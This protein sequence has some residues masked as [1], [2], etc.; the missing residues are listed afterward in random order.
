M[1]V[2]VDEFG[3]AGFF[4][5]RDFVV[6]EFELGGGQVVFELVCLAGADDGGGHTGAVRDPGQGHLGRGYAV[7]VADFHQRFDD[8]EQAF[9]IRNGRFFPAFGKAGAFGFVLVAAVFA[10][11]QAA[12]QRRPYP[13]TVYLIALRSSAN[14][15]WLGRGCATVRWCSA[16][17][18]AFN[19]TGL[20]K[21]TVTRYIAQARSESEG[22]L[23]R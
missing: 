4:D 1:P 20:A 2:G 12:G 13:G 10:G 8:V 22:L 16:L 23:R 17:M 21:A 5:G 6:G 11:E 7:G 19:P 18:V 3:P 15:R 14:S 9:F